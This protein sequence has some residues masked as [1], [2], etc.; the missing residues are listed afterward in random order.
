MWSSFGGQIV[1]DFQYPIAIASVKLGKGTEQWLECSDKPGKI[2]SYHNIKIVTQN[3]KKRS[4][5]NA[6]NNAASINSAIFFKLRVFVYFFLYCFD[7]ENES[8][9]SILFRW[10]TETQICG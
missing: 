4:I 8:T 7:T 10:S 6:N 3:V 2:T 5:A 1:A 9:C